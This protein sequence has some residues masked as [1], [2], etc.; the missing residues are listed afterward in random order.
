MTMFHTAQESRAYIKTL[1]HANLIAIVNS[2]QF[3]QSDR[4][5]AAQLLASDLFKDE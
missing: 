3:T 2:D 1:H 4:N 5:R